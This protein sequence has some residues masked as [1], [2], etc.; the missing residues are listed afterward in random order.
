MHS[1][2]F[3]LDLTIYSTPPMT[4]SC[5]HGLRG[6]LS[7]PY[8]LRRCRVSY[9]TTQ[10]TIFRSLLS[11]SQSKNTVAIC[12]QSILDLLTDV[13][14]HSHREQG[15]E[16][17]LQIKWCDLLAKLRSRM[18]FRLCALA[19]TPRLFALTL[20]PFCLPSKILYSKV[21]TVI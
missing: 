3:V 7:S 15:A 2:T 18:Q 4:S 5:A 13:L 6:G 10:H 19:F 9:T 16:V 1:H 20:P 14:P 12:I 21:T 11:S 8:K 17:A